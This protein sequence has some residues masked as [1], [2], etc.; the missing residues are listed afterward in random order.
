MLAHV[1]RR[2]RLDKHASPSH[3]T[4]VPPIE[5]WEVHSLT[6]AVQVFIRALDVFRKYT[7]HSVRHNDPI[8]E[9]HV[10]DGSNAVR[11]NCLH[12]TRLLVAMTELMAFRYPVCVTS[13]DT[14]S[15]VWK[16]DRL[17]CHVSCSRFSRKKRL[18][19]EWAV[20]CLIELRDALAI[21][22]KEMIIGSVP[23]E[24]SHSPIATLTVEFSRGAERL[25]V[26][27]I[28]ELCHFL[29]SAFIAT[30]RWDKNPET[31]ALVF[32]GVI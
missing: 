16:P 19:A 30:F 4:P 8:I 9:L 31:G 27:E 3:G 15:S 18:T 5:D 20:Q 22:N 6:Q 25:S 1:I 13:A 7:N 2:T 11:I 32:R 24:T 28:Q 14:G 23:L 12:G 10:E 29:S 26:S 21:D 17:K